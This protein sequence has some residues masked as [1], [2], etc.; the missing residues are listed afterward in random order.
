[1][2]VTKLREKRTRKPSSL[3]KGKATIAPNKFRRLTAEEIYQITELGNRKRD[4]E[5]CRELVKMIR[6]R[7]K[8]Q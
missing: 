2:S 8:K 7:E 1:M 5:I 3:P 6:Q 4:S